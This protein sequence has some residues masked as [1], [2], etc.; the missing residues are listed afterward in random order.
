MLAMLASSDGERVRLLRVARRGPRRQRAAA[1]AG[2]DAKAS[3]AATHCPILSPGS[4]G[5]CTGRRRAFVACSNEYPSASSFGSLNAGPKNEIPTGS[6]PVV[7]SGGHDQIREA[8]EVRKVRR[9]I[10]RRPPADSGPALISA[11][12]RAATG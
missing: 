1:Q 6:P 5:V 9:R 12:R 3:L 4:A 8:R 7:K 2:A 11:G 10:R